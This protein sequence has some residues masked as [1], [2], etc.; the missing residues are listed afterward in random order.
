MQSGSHFDGSGCI[1]YKSI[2]CEGRGEA[3]ETCSGPKKAPQKRWC[4]AESGRAT[5]NQP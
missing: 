3:P 2:G 4:T 1:D 5:R